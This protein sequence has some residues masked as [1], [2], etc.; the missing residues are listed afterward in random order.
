MLESSVVNIKGVGEKFAEALQSLNIITISDL[1]FYFP[2]RYDVIE[3]LPLEELIHEDR[4]TI[5]GRV[6]NTPSLSF[7]GRK[8]SRLTF[9]VEID[10]IAVKAVMFNRAFAKNQ[11]KIGDVVTLTGKWDAHRLQITV[12]NYQ[13][14]S[15]ENST[16]IQPIY[17]V[18]GEVTSF[19]LK[20]AIQQAI[21]DYSHF[22]EEI[23]PEDM[24]LSYK[25]PI[26]KDALKTMHFPENRILLKHARRRF[27]YEEFLLFQLK[28][29]ILRKRNREVSLGNVV[30]FD[31][32]KLHQ[33]INRFPFKLTNAQAK[34][35]Q[36]ILNDLKS[37]YR[38]NR[39]LQGDVGSGKT[40]VA[41]MAL[42]AAVT[43]NKQG[44]LMVPTEIL[45]E[46]HIQSLR[47]MFGDLAQIELLTGSIKGKRRKEVLTKLENN[48]VHI[49][50]GTHA[51][52]QDDVHFHDLGLV[53]VDEQHR[54]GV[55]QR[56]ALSNKGLQPDVLFMTATPIPRTLAI[57]AFGDMDVSVIDEMPAGRKEIE[58]YWTKANTF[59]R[60]L[61]FISKHVE[62]GEQAYLICPL[63][64]ESDK[65]DI[66]DAVDLYNQL[67][68][69]YPPSIQVGLMHGRLSSAEKEE[70]MKD[71]AENKVQVLVST[72]VVEVGVNVPNATIMVIYDAERFG[73]SQLHQL[74]G[75][76]G[77]GDKQSYCILIADPKSDTGKERMRIM[78]ETNNGFELSEADLKLRGPG[79]FFG[80]KQSGVPDFKVADMIHDYRALET[81]RTDAQEIIEFNLLESDP[82]YKNLQLFL[83]NEGVFDTV[84]D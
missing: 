11:L 56:R 33:F 10:N 52:I 37:P 84:L 5:E 48:D 72:T 3:I 2:S 4:V 24:L 79:D 62:Q 26:R 77:R 75:R 15:M 51:L 21:Q 74:R 69:Y 44:A 18:R 68:A 47:E 43:A 28:I 1:L 23:L 81:A 61:N 31:T 55:E 19:R 25:I 30:K 71:F 12:S 67:V 40:A 38:M 39:L 46:Q 9:N 22:V 14:G 29:Q 35:L 70:V 53:V 60:V 27:T 66:Q 36:Q 42:Y 41:A 76:V 45:A 78:T 16:E 13:K 17:S 63:I 64:E 50:V 58:T 6:L 32:E 65:L 7:Y 59:D 20:K 8:K 34:S 80:T 54:F 83:E 82:K 57:T 73:L 49:L